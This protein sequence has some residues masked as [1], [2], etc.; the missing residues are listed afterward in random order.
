MKSLSNPICLLNIGNLLSGGERS[1]SAGFFI[2]EHEGY[3]FPDLFRGD[4]PL[5][6]KAAAFL[7]L[8]NATAAAAA[9][10][11]AAREVR[12]LHST[13]FWRGR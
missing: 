6:D 13:A 12:L 3:D 2:S 11:A 10:S 5:I 9:L 7:R 8:C 1:D 4:F